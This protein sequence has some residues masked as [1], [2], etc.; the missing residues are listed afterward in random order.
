MQFTS[1]NFLI[2]FSIIS[3]LYFIIPQKFRW[4]W[5]LICSYYFYMSWSYKYTVLLVASTII[6]Y[7]SGLLIQNANNIRNEKRALQLKK[8]W[9]ILSFSSNLSILFLFEQIS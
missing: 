4:L 1:L 5:L 2:F 3:A 8:L 6:T 7:L 9:V